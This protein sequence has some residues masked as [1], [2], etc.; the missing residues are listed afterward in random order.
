MCLTEQKW[1][2][3][4]FRVPLPVVR[5]VQQSILMMLR[6]FFLQSGQTFQSLLWH[7]VKN[8]NKRPH[9]CTTTEYI[10]DDKNSTALSPKFYC[11][12]PGSW[13]SPVLKFNR[14]A[15]QFFQIWCSVTITFGLWEISS[16]AIIKSQLIELLFYAGHNFI[17]M[18]VRDG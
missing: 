8:G 16:Q 1:K 13:E 5:S 18:I 15:S 10:W 3:K 12:W 14:R 17:M 7:H 9:V 11:D 4:Y 6:D 2:S